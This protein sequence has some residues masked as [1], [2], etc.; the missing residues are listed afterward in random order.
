MSRRMVTV[1]I[2]EDVGFILCAPLYVHYSVEFKKNGL[3][4]DLFSHDWFHA[5]MFFVFFVTSA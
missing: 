5:F 2:L 1:G 3:R 4:G